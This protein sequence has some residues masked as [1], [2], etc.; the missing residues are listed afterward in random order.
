MIVSPMPTLRQLQYLVALADTG[1][2]RRA[3]ETAH[4]SQPTLSSQIR[5]LEQRLG[6]ELVERGRT[7][8]LLTPAGQ[9]TVARAR[10]VLRDVRDIVDLAER[11]RSP[12][13]GTTR[14][15]VL[16]TIG[17]YLLPHVLP[18]L[19][20][21]HPALRLYIREAMRRELMPALTGG[22]LDLAVLPLPV[23]DPEIE[24]ERLF[25]EPLL[26]AV[27]SDHPLADRNPVRR[28]DLAGAPVLALE[29]GHQ[30]HDAVRAL[31]EDCGAELRS[32]FEG[33]S[34]DTLRQMVGM[35]V[36]IAFLPALYV[37]S[38]TGGD[39]QVVIRDLVPPPPRRLIGI[40]WRRSAP[41]RAEYRALAEIVRKE[42]RAAIDEI[43]VATTG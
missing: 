43:V 24:A 21:R 35:G 28:S 32:E 1:G 10:V 4:V 38:E 30:L 34:L 14:L 9:E 40:A 18:G 25:Q 11:S 19:H 2:F 41:R 37:R 15:G 5:A 29:R 23:D 7:R 42:A 31:A 16:P 6:V 12:F 20:H 27:A 39:P 22:A 13:E 3:A 8:V 17:P 26:L 33:T 36:G